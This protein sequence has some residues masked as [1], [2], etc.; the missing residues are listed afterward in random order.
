M[1]LRTCLI[2]LVSLFIAGTSLAATSVTSR[3]IRW[4]FDGDYTTGQFISGDWYVVCPSGCQVTAIASLGANA[5]AGSMLNPTTSS[6]SYASSRP[7]ANNQGFVSGI[8]MPYNASL[9][10]GNMLPLSLSDGDMLCT[11]TRYTGS[12]LYITGLQDGEVLT[13]LASAPAADSFRPGL[14]DSSRTI[15]SGASIDY[16]ELNNLQPVSG[17]PSPAAAAAA[18]SGPWFDFGYGWQGRQ[19][20]PFGNVMDYGGKI[21]SDVSAAALVANCNYSNAEKEP[22]VVALI[23]AGLDAFHNMK[24]YRG[25][26]AAQPAHLMGRKLLA[27]MAG[28]LL[29]IAEIQATWSKSG[30]YLHTTWGG[31]PSDSWRW[32]EDTAHRYVTQ[33]DV[34]A[35]A[36]GTSTYSPDA[37]YTS[38]MIGMPEWFHY[39]WDVGSSTAHWT[40]DNYRRCCYCGPI[41]GQ[42][43]A[44]YAMGWQDLWNH[45]A[46]FDYMDRY[47]AIASGDPD[48]FGYT[49]PGEAS[50]Y[51]GG[52]QVGFLGTGWSVAMWD[53]YRDSFDDQ[54]VIRSNPQPSGTLPAGTTTTT[55]GFAT[56]TATTCKF[57]TS[58]GVEYPDIANTYTTTGGTSHEETLTGLTDGSSTTYYS[59]CGDNSTDYVITV[60]VAEPISGTAWGWSSA[61]YSVG[62]DDGTLQATINRSDTDGAASIQWGTY[63]NSAEV[64]VDYVGVSWTTV[65]FEVGV[66]SVDVYVTILPDDEHEEDENFRLAIGNQSE[67]LISLDEAVVTIVDADSP[68]PVTPPQ[69]LPGTPGRAVCCGGKMVYRQ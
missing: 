22:V 36:S 51:R 7:S 25:F 37:N 41:E 24:S 47:T 52:N 60:A 28:E 44:I 42:T 64:D 54:G 16:N 29:D 45:P 57:G 5:L 10:V 43:L 59:R 38:S 35:S 48:P 62:E 13:V 21:S 55:L 39:H 27:M 8:A 32:S 40:A 58:P 4:S 50:G 2:L 6:Q 31:Y 49:V 17:G 34:S 12:T 61:T 68:P 53:Q 23:Q 15:Y 63:Q 18:I 46:Y 11:G 19:I 56:N 20:H 1:I 26:Y 3:N 33:Q 66:S 67:G 69:V 30:Q 14:T 65:N 9:N